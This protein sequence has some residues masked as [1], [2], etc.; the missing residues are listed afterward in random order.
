MIRKVY[1]ESTLSYSQALT[2][3]EAFKEIHDEHGSWRL[4]TSKTENNVVRVGL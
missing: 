2:Q 3:L 4:S 1:E